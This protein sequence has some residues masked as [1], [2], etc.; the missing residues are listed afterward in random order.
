MMN[1]R[2]GLFLLVLIMGGLSQGQSLDDLTGKTNLGGLLPEVQRAFN[3]MSHAALKDGI[4]IKLVS[5]YRSYERQKQIWNRKYHRYMKM[6]VN[7]TVIID[8]IVT[9]STFPG[10]SRHHWGTEIDVVDGGIDITGEVLLTNNF[11]GEG[12]YCELKEWMDVNSQ[13]YGFVIVYTDNYHRAGFEYEPWHYSYAPISTSYL[14]NYVSQF[15]QIKSDF[16]S[17][18][19][20]GAHLITEKRWNQYLNEHILGINDLLIIK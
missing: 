3:A 14:A 9:Y 2:L 13:R 8:S 6:G 19:I 20:E 4:N 7:P 18:E 11:H 1:L 10:T 16:K 12:P 15:E 5:G 17:S